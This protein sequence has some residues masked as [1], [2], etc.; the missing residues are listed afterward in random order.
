[1]TFQ[2]AI[3]TQEKTFLAEIFAEAYAEARLDAADETGLPLK[4]FPTVPPFTYVQ[5]SDSQYPPDLGG[6]EQE[7]ALPHN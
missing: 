6:P 3:A 2:A 4:T 7:L 1:M 5:A